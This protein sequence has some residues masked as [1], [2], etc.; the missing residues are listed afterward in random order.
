MKKNKK[1]LTFG[2]AYTIKATYQK[3]DGFWATI[4]VTEV[5]RV[6]HGDHE[7][8]NHERA[9]VQFIKANRHLKHLKI[10]RVIYN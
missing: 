3:D 8:G 10:N 6:K 5:V 1:S 4:E 9:E 7:K 2:E